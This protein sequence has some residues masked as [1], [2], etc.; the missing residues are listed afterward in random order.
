MVKEFL[1]FNLKAVSGSASAAA[2]CGPPG[3]GAQSAVSFQSLHGKVGPFGCCRR[4]ITS[5]SSHHSTLIRKKKKYTFSPV[6][7]LVRNEHQGIFTVT[8]FRGGERACVPVPAG[9]RGS[10]CPPESSRR[11]IISRRGKLAPRCRLPPQ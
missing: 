8:F 1:D 5:P 3:R 10:R 4:S 9:Q 7:K 6:S 11:R 2:V